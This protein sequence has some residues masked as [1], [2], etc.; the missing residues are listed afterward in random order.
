MEHRN[1]ASAAGL[2]CRVHDSVL[3]SLRRLTPAY[4][5]TSAGH[6]TASSAICSGQTGLQS[7]P[8]PAASANPSLYIVATSLTGQCSL[9]GSAGT[10]D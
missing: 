7:P 8:A 6:S 3:S 1:V 9:Q 10:F 4:S 5:G 2:S